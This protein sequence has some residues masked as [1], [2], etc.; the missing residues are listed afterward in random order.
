MSRKCARDTASALKTKTREFSS[1]GKPRLAA[2]RRLLS[3]NTDD[4]RNSIPEQ[5]FCAIR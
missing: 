1:I 2:C 3:G 4:V 5:H